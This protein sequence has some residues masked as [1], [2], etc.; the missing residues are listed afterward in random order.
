MIHP[1]GKDMQT[2]SGRQNYVEMSKKIPAGENQRGFNDL[3]SDIK[4]F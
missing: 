2:A 3:K 1:G 4:L